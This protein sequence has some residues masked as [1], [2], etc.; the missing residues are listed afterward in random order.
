QRDA[1]GPGGQ[2]EW[3]KHGPLAGGA[4]GA[5]DELA[6]K[7]LPFPVLYPHP[8]PDDAGIASDVHGHRDAPGRAGGVA[9]EHRRVLPLVVANKVEHPVVVQIDQADRLRVEDPLVQPD[10]LGGVLKRAVTPVAEEVVVTPQAADDQVEL[11]VVVKVAPGGTRRGPER[12]PEVPRLVGDIGKVSLAIVPEQL[13]GA[14]L[15]HEQV[16][17]AVVV[18]VA[19]YRTDATRLV[20]NA[21]VL[22]LDKAVLLVEDEHPRPGPVQ[23]VGPAVAVNVANRQRVALDR[24]ADAVRPQAH[25]DRNVLEPARR[26]GG[27]AR[28]RRGCSGWDL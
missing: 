11:A 16:G 20:G 13:A 21:A 22:R 18:E 14:R 23:E 19:E 12:L 8:A 4:L 1:V 28:S 15:R 25:P 2:G 6:G 5:A 7:D 3:G 9:Q 10:F 24:A 17:E 27:L 26:R